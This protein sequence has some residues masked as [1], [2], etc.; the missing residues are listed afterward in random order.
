MKRHPYLKWLLFALTLLGTLCGA[1]L[2]A[3]A[4]RGSGD[5]RLA[6]ERDT[7][8]RIVVSISARR[9]VVISGASD[10]LL[11]APVAVGSDRLLQYAEHRWT[12]AT[13]RGVRTVIAKDSAPVWIPP[14]WHYV[15]LARREHL[16]LAWLHGDTTLT[17]RDGSVLT[18]RAGKIRV[19]DDSTYD[20][21]EAGDD[22]IADDMLIVP[23]IGS[24]VRRVPGELG[25]FRLS[26]GDGVGIHGTPDKASIGAAV[27]HGC[28]RLSDAQI[29]WLFRRIP[30]GT[31]VYIY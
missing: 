27:T 10:S 14:D 12:F 23:P 9:L 6:A 2:L 8:L 18:M 1:P 7:T 29:E 19:T 22:I 31:R 28:M 24:E 11:V 17:L 25:A 5:I 16:E 30:V 3:H 26:L 21:F 20:D 4:Q 15:E 13:P